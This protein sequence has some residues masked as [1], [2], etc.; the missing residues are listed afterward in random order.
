MQP[1]RG[2]GKAVAGVIEVAR[3][4]IQADEQAGGAKAFGDEGGMPPAAEGAVDDGFAGAWVEVLERLG[5]EDGL[6]AVI[7][8]LRGH[9][10]ARI[11][12]KASRHEGEAAPFH[13]HQAVAVIEA[14]MMW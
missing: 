1:A 9:F 7:G 12:F 13:A 4:G 8:K 14:G 5:G 10:R 11:A 2:A 3:I 6:V